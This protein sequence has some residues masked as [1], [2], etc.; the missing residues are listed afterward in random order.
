MNF[1]KKSLSSEAIVTILSEAVNS[2]K[3]LATDLTDMPFTY[4]SGRQKMIYSHTLPP[5]GIRLHK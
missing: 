5:G 2:N 4:Q 3:S 1:S